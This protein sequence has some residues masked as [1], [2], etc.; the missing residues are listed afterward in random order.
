MVFSILSVETFFVGNRQDI[1][2]A[3]N[4]DEVFCQEDHTIITVY[5]IYR[6]PLNDPTP[7][8]QLRLQNNRTMLRIF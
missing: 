6:G 1:F 8:L 4:D 2:F 5:C 3:L 7:R